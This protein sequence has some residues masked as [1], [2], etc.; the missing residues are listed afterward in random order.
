MSNTT[1]FIILCHRHIRYS[2]LRIL[3]RQTDT[4]VFIIHRRT[5]PLRP[6]AITRLTVFRVDFPIFF[7]FAEEDETD[8]EDEAGEDDDDDS[9]A[10]R[11]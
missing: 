7:P 2:C 9:V 10:G 3:H 5:N 1:T 6:F 8:K 11:I 4:T